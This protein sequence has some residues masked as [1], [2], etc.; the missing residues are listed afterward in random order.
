MSQ[1][2]FSSILIII[3]AIVLLVGGT[4]YYFLNKKVEPT[5]N[6]VVTS[7]TPKATQEPT[8]Q[9][10]QNK[11]TQ[12]IAEGC[13]ITPYNGKKLEFGDVVSDV[14]GG[15][16]CNF[17]IHDGLPVYNFYFKGNAEYNTIDRIEITKGIESKVLVQTLEAG[18]GEPPP[19]GGKFFGAQDMNFD[20]YKDIRLM[21]WWGATGNTGYT[22][23]LFDPSKNIFVENSDLSSLS[24]PTPEL[25]TKTIAT[26]SVGGMASCI[27]NNGTYKFDVDGKLILIRSEKQDYVEE[28]KSFVKTIGELKDGKMVTST[29][30]GDCGNF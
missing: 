22:Y 1:K 26:H 3:I 12:K 7:I 19:S 15:A 21:S 27:Y 6:N 10:S 23:W 20:G 5:G 28:S 29:V 25:Q 11:N 24:N 18:M 9:L 30:A 13:V 2:G 4:A 16:I 14:R 17:Y 8:T